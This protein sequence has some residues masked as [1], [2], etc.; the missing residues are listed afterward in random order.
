MSQNKITEVPQNVKT[1]LEKD[2]LCWSWEESETIQDYLQK[3][4]LYPKVPTEPRQP[5]EL[6][7]FWERRGITTGC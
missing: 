2:I 6:P 7:C 3:N 1:I 4:D 5:E